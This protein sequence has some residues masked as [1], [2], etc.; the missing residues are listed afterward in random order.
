[1]MTKNIKNKYTLAL[2]TTSIF[3]ISLIAQVSASTSNSTATSNPTPPANTFTDNR[4]M[5][6]LQDV[7]GLDVDKYDVTLISSKVRDYTTDNNPIG[8]LG[9]IQTNEVY[10]LVNWD[11]KTEMYSDL[12]VSFSYINSTL[13]S[14]SLK[15]ESGLAYSSKPLSSDLSEAAG[16]FLERYNSF[17]ADT[18]LNNM[19]SMLTAV[20]LNT[21]QSKTSSN[22]K[23]E[24][25]VDSDLTSIRWVRTQNGVDYS[26]LV[27][28]FKN[29]TFLDFFDSRSYITIG[30]SEV[31]IS[32]EQAINLALKQADGFS[33]SYNGV[34]VENLTIVEDKIKA[35]LKANVRYNPSEYYP[36]WT[37]DLPLNTVYPGSIYYI[38]VKIWADDGQVLYCKAMGYGGPDPGNSTIDIGQSETLPLD[39]TNG[40]QAKTNSLTTSTVVVT[41]IVLAILLSVF[42][43][44]IVIK[45]R[46]SK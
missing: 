22:L 1:M 18:E 2:L 21:N 29:G 16:N 20:D 44:A 28:N 14:C 41:T 31:N 15:V 32:K 7:V 26:Q 39:N 17:S 19:I 43:I 24:V 42:T 27:L 12:R 10:E 5:I 46:K 13:R 45:K 11:M 6:F 8:N 40:N 23:L 35:E 3:L 37:I 4:A 30:D 33:Y 9:Y 38:Q 25:K 34:I 36:C